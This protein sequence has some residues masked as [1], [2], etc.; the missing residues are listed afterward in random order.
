MSTNNGDAIVRFVLHDARE[1]ANEYRLK[2]WSCDA[3]SIGQDFGQLV[4]AD[5]YLG[6]DKLAV[7]AARNELHFL[8]RYT[9]GWA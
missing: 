4:I 5:V 8:R 1:R 7:H 3:F 2:G 6:A 9:E